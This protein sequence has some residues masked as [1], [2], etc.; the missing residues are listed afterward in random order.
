M[1]SV[2][3]LVVDGRVAENERMGRSGRKGGERE[4]HVQGGERMEQ[5]QDEGSPK[6]GILTVEGGDHFV[7]TCRAAE[8]GDSGSGGGF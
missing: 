8:E 3:D 5:E 6:E 4:S 2:D 1:D 7:V